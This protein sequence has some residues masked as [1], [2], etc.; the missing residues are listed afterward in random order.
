LAAPSYRPATQS[1][2]LR[3][4]REFLTLCPDAVYAD[5]LSLASVQ[6]YDAELQ[7]R[8]QRPGSRHT[9]IA[10][11]KAFFAFL[12][13]RGAL[14]TPITQAIMV[15]TQG[16]AKP[17]RPVDA[18]EAALLLRAAQEGRHAR[19]IALIAVLLHTGIS[20]SDVTELTLADLIL[21]P[22][23]DSGGES[24]QEKQSAPIHSI[25][26]K[27][28]LRYRPATQCQEAPLDESTWQALNAYLAVRPMSP[29]PHLFL[30]TSATP[31][32]LQTVGAIVK[33]YARAAGMPWI[34]ARA[35][36]S[37]FILRQLAAGT[38][39]PEVQICAGQ[40][41]ITATRRYLGMLKSSGH[42][43][44]AYRRTC[45]VLIVDQHRS[46]RRQLRA[47]LES[48]G[49]QVFEASDSVVARD[50]LRLSR[51]SLVVLITLSAHPK[52]AF[53][54]IQNLADEQRLLADHRVVLIMLGRQQVPKGLI[55][56]AGHDIPVVSHAIPFHPVLAHIARAYAE[57]GAREWMDDGY[58]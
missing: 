45:G 9:K 43:P 39:L 44:A 58:P 31:L 22:T 21:T 32:T 47:L 49:H 50:M 17:V 34:Q 55:N 5:D 33:K 36:R 30:T 10:A 13:E 15:P 3:A 54:L 37:G 20:F 41:N 42:I 11:V 53:D 23:P 8:Q 18:D 12:E 56:P 28:R 35:L 19:D 46:T 40:R 25:R 1:S 26:C 51:L 4:V 7:R 52:S 48:A 27:L 14:S 38:P 29:D 57:L 24:G 6:R 16:G 2:Y